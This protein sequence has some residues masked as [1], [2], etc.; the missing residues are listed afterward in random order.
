MNVV[1]DLG[2][3]IAGFIGA[4]FQFEEGALVVG[5]DALR[6]IAVSKCAKHSGQ[7]IDH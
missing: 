6:Q 5:V 4:F 2:Q 1:D 7:V 3:A